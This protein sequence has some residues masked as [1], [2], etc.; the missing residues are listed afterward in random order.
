MLNRRRT[1]AVVL[2]VLCGVLALTAYGRVFFRWRSAS[3]CAR[4]LAD[5]GGRPAYSAPVT[6][7]GGKGELD[8]FSFDAPVGDLAVRLARVFDVPALRH[9]GGEMATG[10]VRHDGQVIRLTLARFS[11]GAQTLVFALSQE[12]AEYEASS[13]PDRADIPPGIPLYPG[14]RPLFCARDEKA[15]MHFLVARAHADPAVIHAT[16]RAD[17]VAAGWEPFFTSRGGGD[18]PGERRGGDQLSVQFYL[19]PGRL[20]CV[21]AAPSREGN[22]TRITVLQKQQQIP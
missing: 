5:A 16:L 11:R 21:H 14:A 13:V 12:A 22:A 7:N 18:R 19:K 4:A 8:V 2:A 10:L 9:E 1:T 17:L 6:L 20:C 3:R 15:Q